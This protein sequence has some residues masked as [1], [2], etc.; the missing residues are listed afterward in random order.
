MCNDMFSIYILLLILRSGCTQSARTRNFP[1]P[2]FRKSYHNLEIF[3]KISSVCANTNWVCTSWVPC[4]AVENSLLCW[5]IVFCDFQKSDVFW[6]N[7]SSSQSVYYWAIC[8]TVDHGRSGVR[9][10]LGPS[11]PPASY[12]PCLPSFCAIVSACCTRLLPHT[13]RLLS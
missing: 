9:F 6:Q 4:A 1:I 7:I 2:N 3:T 10:S 5:E 12:C 11:R 8:S 13:L